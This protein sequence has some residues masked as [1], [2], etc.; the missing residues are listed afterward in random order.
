M[1]A[2]NLS[3]KLSHLQQKSPPPTPPIL[4]KDTLSLKTLLFLGYTNEMTPAYSPPKPQKPFII[5]RV[6]IH[7]MLYWAE[8]TTTDTTWRGGNQTRKIRFYFLI[9]LLIRMRFI[10]FQMRQMF[11]LTAEGMGKF[12][13]PRL[14]RLCIIPNQSLVALGRI[15]VIMIKLK[16]VDSFAIA[17]KSM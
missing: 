2:T 1:G 5:Q 15:M 3:L 16:I 11:T 4:E 14:Q 10:H 12:R 17:W 7:T 6:R 8:A 13:P 9:L